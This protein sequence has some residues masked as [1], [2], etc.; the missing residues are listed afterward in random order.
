MSARIGRRALLRLGVA[1]GALGLLGA[2]ELVQRHL[3]SWAQ[4]AAGGGW[5]RLLVEGEGPG[6][7]H[8]HT[9]TAVPGRGVLLLFGGR[10]GSEAPGDDLWS[11]DLGA[12]H[13][14]R[15][16]PGG[17][18]PPARADH[19]AIY[20][21]RQ[22]RLLVFGGRGGGALYDDLWA[23]SLVEGRWGQVAAVTRPPARYGAASVLDEEAGRWLVSHGAGS[24][25]LLDDTWQF[26]LGEDRWE[27]LAPGGE[28]PWA[29]ALTCGVWDGRRKRLVLIGGESDST[30][31]EEIWA[32]DPASGWAEL[33]PP[34]RPPARAQH[35]AAYDAALARIVL[36]GGRNA[37]GA[38]GDLWISG[39]G[40][41]WAR[42]EV[43]SEAPSARWGHALA[44]DSQRGRLYLYGGAASEDF[45]DLWE[46]SIP[47]IDTV[48]A[49]Y[50]PSARPSATPREYLPSAL[51][52][53]GES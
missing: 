8:G 27:E 16:A 52:T 39:S 7:R 31:L 32:L 41:E 38:L 48:L 4:E 5:R 13:W 18:A 21:A 24:A 53:P 47:L 19:H 22:E 50:T 23:Y 3:T 30:P 9:L 6:P 28:R 46:L 2:H 36:F 20:D 11:F 51:P 43:G 12:S 10:R 45:D 25:G 33:R 29:R 26:L 35:A 42:L 34:L 1:A 14:A 49:P 37:S 44:Y 40:A 15:L 17:E